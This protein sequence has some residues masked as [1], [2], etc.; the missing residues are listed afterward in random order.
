MAIWL[1]PEA[2]PSSTLEAS[3]HGLGSICEDG[4]SQ[5][6]LAFPEGLP[7]H[8]DYFDFEDHQKQPKRSPTYPFLPSRP[9]EAHIF[10]PLGKASTVYHTYQKRRAVP[11]SPKRNVHAKPNL[12]GPHRIRHS[13]TFDTNNSESFEHTAIWDQKAILSLGTSLLRPW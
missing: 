13:S 4:Q 3:L 2:E 10:K 11:P 12:T 9:S 1:E 7:V 5:V 8:S 6:P